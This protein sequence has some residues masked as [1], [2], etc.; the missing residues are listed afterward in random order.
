[1][2]SNEIV[3]CLWLDDQAEQAA[4]LYLKAFVDGRVLGTSRYPESRDNPSGRPRGSVLTVDLELAGRRFTLL[5]GGPMF[6]PNPSVSFFAHVETPA[7]ADRLYGALAEGGATLMPLGSYPWSERYAWVADRFGVSWQVITGRRPPGGAA[8]APCLMFVGAQHG[9]AE[10]AMRF[11]ED[12]FPGSRIADVERYA[13]G[14]GL[15]GSVKH[16]RFVLAGQDLVA[17]DGPGP[18][19]F[20][21]D[22]GVSLQVMCED[23]A[24]LDR[25][26]DAL[27]AGGSHGPCGWLKDRFGLS[28]QV[29]PAEIS[30]WMTSRDTAAR[31]RAFQAV[32]GMGKLDVAA[33]RRAFEGR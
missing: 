8:I 25:Y 4:A 28:W 12:V 9:R 15:E 22:E 23:Q 33:I 17:M 21:F 27:A 18:H 13:A 1:M 11:Y 14:E 3:P 10:E 26:W 6:E 31:D 2:P 32:M 30:T 20:G 29:V 16:G 24:T 7:A 5:N 19:R